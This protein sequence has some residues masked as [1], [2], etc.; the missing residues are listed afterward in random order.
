[1]ERQIIIRK[2]RTESG[3]ITMLPNSQRDGA[4]P[5]QKIIKK[6]R[7]PSDAVFTITWWQVCEAEATEKEND[8]C[9]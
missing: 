3:Q 4:D 7:L 8:R 6:A 5:G 1:M 9:R 2:Q